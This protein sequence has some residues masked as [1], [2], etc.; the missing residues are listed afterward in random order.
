MHR[1]VALPIARFTLAGG[2]YLQSERALAHVE[3]AVADARALARQ[4]HAHID[5]A[6][7]LL[8]IPDVNFM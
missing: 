6:L 3:V 2:V 1:L 7:Q 8:N 4:R 5:E